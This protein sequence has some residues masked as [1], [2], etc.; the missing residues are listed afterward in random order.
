MLPHYLLVSFS[1]TFWSTINSQESLYKSCVV[2]QQYPQRLM[3]TLPLERTKPN[4][5][6]TRATTE[7]YGNGVSCDTLLMS[8]YSECI[9]HSS[10]DYE[11]VSSDCVVKVNADVDI[12]D[13]GRRLV[14][15][16]FSCVVKW[17]KG[18][19]G[20]VLIRHKWSRPREDR[21]RRTKVPGLRGRLFATRN[22]DGRWPLKKLT[23]S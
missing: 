2:T 18:L 20:R 22:V 13:V 21:E 9:L 5:C 17:N 12:M 7:L 3:E 19:F 14:D 11:T 15:H 16:G 6:D 1:R 10:F 23:I 4:S 8:G